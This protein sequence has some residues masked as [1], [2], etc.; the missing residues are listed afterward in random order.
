MF[1]FLKEEDEE[2]TTQLLNTLK[3]ILNS[4]VV[5]SPIQDERNIERRAHK[6][7]QDLFNNKGLQIQGTI[8]SEAMKAN[9][10]ATRKLSLGGGG[11]SMSGKEAV[12]YMIHI[13]KF[14][15]EEMR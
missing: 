12:D 3:E 13:I 10:T 4:E 1:R 11:T 5:D 9:I 2:L 14:A 7:M 6:C 15:T 8:F